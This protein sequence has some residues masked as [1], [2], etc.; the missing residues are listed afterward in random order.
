MDAAPELT[1][2]YLQRVRRWWAGKDPAAK[3]QIIRHAAQADAPTIGAGVGLSR[4]R[5]CLSRAAQACKN[6]A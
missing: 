1:R 4:R 2:T 6:P 3:Q 5:A